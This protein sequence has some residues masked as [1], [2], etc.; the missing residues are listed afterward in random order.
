MTTNTD[1]QTAN[2]LS[3]AQLDGVAGGKKGAGAVGDKIAGQFK[4]GTSSEKN[5]D[6]TEDGW[7]ENA[8]VNAA[9]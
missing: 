7:V 2:E 4:K 9:S 8:S 3:D 1:N 5:K 6:G